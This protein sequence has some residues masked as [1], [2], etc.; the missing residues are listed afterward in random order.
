MIVSVI[1]HVCFGF[2]Y[3]MCIFQLN[4]TVELFIDLSKMRFIQYSKSKPATHYGVKP[5]NVFYVNG[6]IGEFTVSQKKERLKLRLW[7]TCSLVHLRVW[8]QSLMC[9]VISECEG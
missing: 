5:S 8:L 4:I 2:F 9:M 7:E 3:N 1:V 6:S